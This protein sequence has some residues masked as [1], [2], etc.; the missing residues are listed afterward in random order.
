MT[1][2]KKPTAKEKKCKSAIEG[3][4]VC[5]NISSV[6]KVPFPHFHRPKLNDEDVPT[7][8]RD[9][10]E[11]S[12]PFYLEELCG[13]DFDKCLTAF[14]N[15][16]NISPTIYL[17]ETN[18]KVVEV[19]KFTKAHHLLDQIKTYSASEME[20][21]FYHT[22]SQTRNPIQFSAHDFLKYSYCVDFGQK[23]VYTPIKEQKCGTPYLRI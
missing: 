15:S 16:F 10:R 18:C 6:H 12:E 4:P 20:K 8:A 13:A 19:I 22:S 17:A 3:A 7:E 21:S 2:H 23:K 11:Y 9:L 1:Y 14:L 5:P